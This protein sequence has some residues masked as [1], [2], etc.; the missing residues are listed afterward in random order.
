MKEKRKSWIEVELGIVIKKTCKN[1]SIKEAHNYIFGYTIANDVTMNNILGRDHHLIRSK[2][3]DTFCPI[4][5]H[6]E[7]ELDTS[8][9]SL[10]SKV[11]GEIMQKS[12]VNKRILN[13][14]QIVNLISEKMTLY[15][16]DL[17]ITGTP[18]NAENS[19]IKEG[20]FVEL[21]IEN[22]GTLSNYVAFNKDKR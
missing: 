12:N 14:F 6:I 5:P 1:I 10:I 8:D 13:D 4:G 9:L 19:I 15:A 20:D 7:T 2:G 17:I 16:G 18:A 21:T 3:W 11:N 22:L